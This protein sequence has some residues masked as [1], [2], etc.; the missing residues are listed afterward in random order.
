M[1]QLNLNASQLL[2]L[3]L[4][5]SQLTL[6]L[7][8]GKVFDWLFRGARLKELRRCPMCLGFWTSL[9]VAVP[10]GIY[11][12]FSILAIAAVG[13]LIFLARDKY[14]PCDKCKIPEPISF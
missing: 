9:I 5:Q 13:H 12:P 1:M 11:N 4:A 6:L 8:E 2:L 14:L 7:A 10:T 3:P